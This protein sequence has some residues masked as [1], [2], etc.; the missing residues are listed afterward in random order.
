M[1]YLDLLK[2]AL[3]ETVI[4]ITALLT[5]GAHVIQTRK[6]RD[7]RLLCTTIAA[8]GLI[9]AGF[10]VNGLPAYDPARNHAF[11]SMLEIDP[12]AKFFKL[13]VI[14]LSFFTVLL[15][16]GQ[17][18]GKHTGEYFTMILL[19]TIGLMLMM[20]SGEFLMIFIGL[21]LAGLSL[22]ILAAFDKFQK[23]SIEAGLK[24]FM[25]GST[26]SAFTLFGLSLV[27]GSCGT[28]NL[29]EI[30]IKLV[31]QPTETA[32]LVA[33]IQ[34]A[35]H[36]GNHPLHIQPLLAAGIIMT[37]VGFAFKIAAAPFHL[38][39]PDAYEGAPISTAAL[40]AS[41][42]KVAS[43]VVLGK[44]FLIGFAPVHVQLVPVIAAL[45]TVSILLGNIAALA[46]SSVRRL[47]A[48]S[49]VAHG[50]YTL[51]GFI[52]GQGFSSTLFYTTTYAVTLIGAFGVVSLIQAQ[53]GRDDIT[54]FAGLRSRSP[55]LAVCMS[56]FFLSLAGLPPLS[57][58]F[59][60]L[61]LFGAVLSDGHIGLVA[62]ALLGSLISLYYYLAVLRQVL[63]EEPAKDAVDV[64]GDS[65]QNIS[66]V[67]LSL[68]VVALGV[69][70][71]LLL[72]WIN[73]ALEASFLK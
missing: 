72:N 56:I 48:Y 66:L 52:N 7:T 64:K 37:L 15:A 45:A 36:L 27:Y 44:I 14:A 41:G 22:Y 49:A 20:S 53:T 55:L 33:V 5:L 51:L 10:V 34:S 73:G 2:L 54:S 40:I 12:L 28:T 8:L 26:A 11:G 35:A 46:Q 50:G 60:K 4:T 3:P 67:F 68:A 69:A 23:R 29:K 16:K 17:R 31:G 71:D 70:P 59:G 21:E 24:Y 42:S 6:G 38:W 18:F 39:A 58:F 57:G 9:V 25:F 63:I 19:A 62:V 47:L 1:N 32:P 61:Y 43:F 65:I 13:I 30:A